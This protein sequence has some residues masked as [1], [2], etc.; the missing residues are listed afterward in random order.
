MHMAALRWALDAS[1][2]EQVLQEAHQLKGSLGNLG[3]ARF[4]DLAH[5]IECQARAGSLEG[6]HPLAEALPAAYEEALD[7]L[8]A[9]FPR[10]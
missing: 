1:D 6:T 2:A 7:A 10:T 3:L 5:R 4:A 9:A 8:R